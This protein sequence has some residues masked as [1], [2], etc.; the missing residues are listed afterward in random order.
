MMS[1]QYAKYE[2]YT[3]LPTGWGCQCPDNTNI[4][5]KEECLAVASRI[6]LSSGSSDSDTELMLSQNKWRYGPMRMFHLEGRSK[7]VLYG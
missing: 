2:G 3:V 7:S 1:I 5:S 6:L 4:E